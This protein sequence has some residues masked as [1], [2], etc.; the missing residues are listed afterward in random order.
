MRH[1]GP[2]L[3]GHI[4]G[5]DEPDWITV[6]EDIG[7]AG[8]AAEAMSRKVEDETEIGD[9]DA[10]AAVPPAPNASCFGKAA[11]EAGAGEFRLPC[12]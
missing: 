7:K 9:A 4:E 6:R 10:K 1:Q 2:Q 11:L 12:G 5:R 8:R 3:L